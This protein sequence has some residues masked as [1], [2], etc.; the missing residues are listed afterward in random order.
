VDRIPRPV[1]V[2]ALENA[3]DVV[4]H[5]DGQPNPDRPNIT[6]VT[7]HHDHGDIGRN[8]DLTDSYIPGATDVAAS[9]DPSVRAYLG[10]LMPFLSATT[11]QTQRFLISR[12]YR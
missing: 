2:L 11:I 10:G 7:L 8:H 1:Q 4:P 12:T 3:G 9:S 6:T 5:L